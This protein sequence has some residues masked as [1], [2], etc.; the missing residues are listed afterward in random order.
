MSLNHFTFMTEGNAQ[1]HANKVI[2][3][4]ATKLVIMA[5]R[6]SLPQGALIFEA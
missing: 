5:T 3:M 1:E 6:D 4:H 2:K